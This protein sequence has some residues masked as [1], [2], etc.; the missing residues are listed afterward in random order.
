MAPVG[1]RGS[2]ARRS[3]PCPPEPGLLGFTC[4]SIRFS[5]A[6]AHSCARRVRKSCARRSPAEMGVQLAGLE[7]QGSRALR[8]TPPT[9]G[10]PGALPASRRLAWKSGGKENSGRAWSMCGL[11]RKSRRSPLAL[12]DPV[13]VGPADPVALHP[14][15]TAPPAARAPR[16]IRPSPPAAAPSRRTRGHECPRGHASKRRSRTGR[17][18]RARARGRR[19]RAK[20]QVSAVKRSGPSPSFPQESPGSRG[21]M[22]SMTQSARFSGLAQPPTSSKRSSSPSSRREALRG[23]PEAPVVR[24]HRFALTR[25]GTAR[26]LWNGATYLQ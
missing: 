13:V 22:T 19:C 10:S 5:L 12:D 23:L 26:N 15:G 1:G 17:H 21:G 14:R 9:R 18:R 25:P 2:R 6:V 20:I 16:C 8:W 7:E 24:F 11:K 4:P 3:I